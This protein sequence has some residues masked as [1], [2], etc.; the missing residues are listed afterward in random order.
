MVSRA[1]VFTFIAPTLLSTL[2]LACGDDGT[3]MTTEAGSTSTTDGTTGTT[4]TTDTTGTTGDAPTSTS[5]PTTTT[6][7]EGTTTGT[8]A[9]MTT[10]T[11]SDTTS[12]TT[13]GGGVDCAAIPMGPFEP[14]YLA[15]G[16]NGSEDLGFDGLGGLA[17][18]GGEQLVIAPA[19]FNDV[20][21]VSGL[22]QV[23][24]TR[25]A[26]NGDVLLALPNQ[27]KLQA[28]DPAGT[29]TDVATG[30]EGPNG[31]YVDPTGAIWVTEFSGSRVVHFTADYTKT[32][33][34]EGPMAS[35][36]NGV[37]LDPA[38]GLL[39]F[40]NYGAGRLLKIAVDDQ[41][42]AQGAPEEVGAV[43][44]ARL[45]GL[46]LDACGNIYAVDQGND[47]VYRFWLDA[48]AVLVGAPELLAEFDDNVA[49]AQFGWGP[50]WEPE[51]LY[52]AGNPGEIYELPVGVPGAPIGLVN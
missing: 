50:G 2:V 38:R 8:T 51:S 20:L 25:F 40:T 11:T 21:L 9:S 10:S 24:G 52:L 3:G 34:Y 15:G 29:I 17:L 14:V 36:A 37:V 35:S 5:S 23:Y 27:G 28:V 46:V 13:T 43:A 19:D 4:G 45:D 6:T 33:V 1:S 32:V 30:L 47:R 22:P 31:L 49:N 42:Q 7:S 12:D 48:Q 16:Y 18:K 41:G 44:G 39:F 26:T